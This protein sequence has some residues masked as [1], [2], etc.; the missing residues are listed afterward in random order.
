MSLNTSQNDVNKASAGFTLK[1]QPSRIAELN[2]CQHGLEALIRPNH[3]IIKR[4]HTIF[5]KWIVYDSM[6]NRL[7][8][9]KLS[10]D[11]SR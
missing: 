9:A 10:K 2:A 11:F 7:F 4:C 8:T 3:L 1:N 6:N 5:I